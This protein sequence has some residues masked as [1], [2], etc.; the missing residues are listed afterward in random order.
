M[1]SWR[2]LGNAKPKRQ[3]AYQDVGNLG[4]DS[5]D[6][7]VVQLALVV[8]E[9]QPRAAVA[10]LFALLQGTLVAVARLVVVRI[11]GAVAHLFVLPSLV[12]F[13]YMVGEGKFALAVVVVV[14][15]AGQADV[16]VAGPVWWTGRRRR[17]KGGEGGTV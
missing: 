5:V 17:D 10:C 14:A 6:A 8:A 4:D 2:R 13:A 7:N 16:V 15:G 12:V 3:R 9:G 11:P 1:R